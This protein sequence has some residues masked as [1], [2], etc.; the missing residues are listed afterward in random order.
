MLRLPPTIIITPSLYLQVFVKSASG[1]VAD[2]LLGAAV[3]TTL[4]QLIQ[5]FVL[6]L[7]DQ[8]PGALELSR[9]PARRVLVRREPGTDLFVVGQCGAKCGVHERKRMDRGESPR[10][11][12]IN[13]IIH[14]FFPSAPNYCG[15]F[16]LA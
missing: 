5:Y 3:L 15:Y 16:Y 6:E 7:T 9:V 12:A 4:P 8:S 13:V 1:V 14:V 2:G 10:K 11:S